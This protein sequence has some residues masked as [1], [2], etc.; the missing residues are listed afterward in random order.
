[1]EQDPVPCADLV[2]A[3]I[4]KRIELRRRFT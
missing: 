3:E 2:E 4:G 1:M